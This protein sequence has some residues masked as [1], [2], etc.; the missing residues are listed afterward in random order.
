[1]GIRHAHQTAVANNAGVDVSATRWNQDHVLSDLLFPVITAVPALDQADWAPTGWNDAQP[2]R[3]VVIRAQP[4]SVSY[5]SGLVGGADGRVA[6]IKNDTVDGLIC[7]CNEDTA[8]AA[9]NRF[10]TRREALWLL[11]EQQARFNYDGNEQRWELASLSFDARAL[12]ID[13]A[14]ILPNTTTSVQSIGI[15]TSNTATLSTI[16]P[17]AT[18]TNELDARPATQITN[19]TANGSSD[20]RGNALNYMRGATA[21]RQGFFFESL[22]RIT[23]ASA[24]GGAMVGM[25]GS[26]AALTGLPSTV[27]NSLY[28]GI[29]QAGQTTL[30]VGARDGSAFT[31]VDLGANY[32]VPSATASY[33]GLL[34]AVPGQ[35]RVVYALRRLDA[36]FRTGGALTANL[37]AATTGLTLRAN[38]NVGATGAA[39]T[40]RFGRLF[41]RHL[42]Y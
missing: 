7:V 1:M 12:D 28:F 10:A 13:A 26:T 31:E 25:V 29:G 5:L 23:A 32:P 19:S 40:L 16:A 14:I 34:L 3:A 37:P 38:I 2:A 35:S 30:R 15:G 20:V 24:T 11:P 21:R 6:V 4:A 17:T 42:N 22:F 39:T 36:A 18:P 27:N 41:A 8:S 33:N 9:A